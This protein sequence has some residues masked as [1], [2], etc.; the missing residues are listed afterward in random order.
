MLDGS[1]KV[2]AFFPSLEDI[3]FHSF[4]L[5]WNEPKLRHKLWCVF[6]K[7]ALPKLGCRFHKRKKTRDSECFWLL[8]QQVQ[9]RFCPTVNSTGTPSGITKALLSG[10]LNS[11]SVPTDTFR[12]P[13]SHSSALPTGPYTIISI[14]T[15]CLPT[16]SPAQGGRD[17]ITPTK[18]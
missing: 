10:G 13:S 4:C 17:Y 8:Q 11:H 2:P 14:M 12:I 16:T 5:I 1:I 18:L 9:R 6:W 15:V 3:K 7:L